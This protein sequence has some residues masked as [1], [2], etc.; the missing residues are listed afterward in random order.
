MDGWD[1]SADGKQ[2]LLY[3]KTCDDAKSAQNG[4][5]DILYGC[6]TILK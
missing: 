3:G 6:P 4:K 2:V 1:Y 5:I